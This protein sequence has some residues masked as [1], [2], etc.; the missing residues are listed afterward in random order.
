MKRRK[1]LLYEAAFELASSLP[2]S[3][4]S[5]GWEARAAELAPLAMALAIS[6]R[7]KGKKTFSGFL[8]LEA[9]S[10]SMTFKAF[11]QT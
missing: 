3:P 6:L 8:N 11:V 7:V 2:L 9:E 10:T 1:C 5:R 4:F